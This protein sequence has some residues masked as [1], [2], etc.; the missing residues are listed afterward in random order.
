MKVIELSFWVPGEPATFA[1]SGERAWRDQLMRKI[2]RRKGNWRDTFHKVFKDVESISVKLRDA[3]PIRNALAHSRPLPKDSLERL[4]VNS[5]DILGLMSSETE[6]PL[7]E[8][9]KS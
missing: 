8:E 1:T 3:E 9:C 6:Q 7:T 2:I 5:K 4:R